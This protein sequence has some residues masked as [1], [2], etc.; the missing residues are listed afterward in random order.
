MKV[1]DIDF[2]LDSSRMLTCGEDRKFK[3][4]DPASAWGN[5]YES[6]D[7]GQTVW[8][9]AYAY[10]GYVGVGLNSGEVRVYNSEFSSY[11]SYTPGS[12]GI[13]YGLDFKYGTHTFILGSGNT[14]GYTSEST[15]DIID[16]QGII[17]VA[18][19]ARSAKFFIFSGADF[20]VHLF[21]SS[22]VEVDFFPYGGKPL[23]CGDFSNF[24]DN[25]CV[26]AV[27]SG[28]G[29]VYVYKSEGEGN[30]MVNEN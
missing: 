9:C 2:L 26:F 28:S 12:A 13:P 17:Y 19:Y 8:S 4:W 18:K 16:T 20:K 5:T 15:S 11:T 25:G 6:S 14:K 23:F 10:D 3:V 24:G 22:N 27:G 7:L 1:H 21:N 30:C 29:R